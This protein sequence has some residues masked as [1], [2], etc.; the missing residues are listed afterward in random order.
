MFRETVCVAA[1][2]IDEGCYDVP[3]PLKMVTINDDNDEDQE[4]ASF[5]GE[6]SSSYSD[7]KMK[8]ISEEPDGKILSCI[9]FHTESGP[10]VH[11]LK[12]ERCVC[13]GEY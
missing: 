9:E 4:E 6:P 10:N 3:V 5:Q 8:D 7:S 2:L 12:K 13:S 11:V 1:E